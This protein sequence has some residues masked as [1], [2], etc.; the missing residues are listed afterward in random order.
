MEALASSKGAG[1]LGGV[2]GA[3]KASTT[4]GLSRSMNGGTTSVRKSANSIAR[5]RGALG[6]SATDGS[7]STAR[8]GGGRS[9]AAAG[10]GFVSV[11]SASAGRSRWP[12]ERNQEQEHERHE[13]EVFP[14]ERPL[15]ARESWERRQEEEEEGA[16][17]RFH[18]GVSEGGE[19]SAARGVWRQ[20]GGQRIRKNASSTPVNVNG[21]ADHDGAHQYEGDP[22]RQPRHAHR[23]AGEEGLDDGGQDARW[24][25]EA[26]AEGGRRLDSQNPG[27]PS[28]GG[29]P[30]RA[31]HGGAAAGR[32]PNG[33]SGR[34]A[35]SRVHDGADQPL[36]DGFRRTHG[37][38][39]ERN[40]PRF[41]GDGSGRDRG[42]DEQQPGRQRELHYGAAAPAFSHG[43]GVEIRGRQDG[44]A[45]ARDD[46]SFYRD[47]NGSD[48]NP[49]PLDSS[50]GVRRSSASSP[51]GV[52]YDP[53]RYEKA[54][55]SQGAAGAGAGAAEGG[56]HG[57]WAGAH[58]D[59]PRGERAGGGGRGEGMR[60]IN[61]DGRQSMRASASA[62]VAT[63]DRTS[64]LR[65][66]DAA[67]MGGG[68]WAHPRF[69]QA[70]QEGPAAADD[71]ER[72]QATAGDSG[73]D[74]VGARPQD[75]ER[76]N[77][78]REEGRKVGHPAFTGGR[79][80]HER[81]HQQVAM[82]MTQSVDGADEDVSRSAERDRA[83][84]VGGAG[85]PDTATTADGLNASAGAGRGLPAGGGASGSGSGSGG[86][87]EHVLRD[88][89]RV[90]LFANG[91]QKVGGARMK[92]RVCTLGCVGGSLP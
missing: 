84:V 36:S 60:S 61:S 12:V 11:E 81:A 16:N 53:M 40:E 22:G 58:P 26:G 82:A 31:E 1:V 24:E 17:M 64:P 35:S 23:W 86:K 41:G 88:G 32:D 62:A 67:G 69:R 37:V 6:V 29:L 80:R 27:R 76:L 90:I 9:T 68:R 74:G 66:S 25:E 91:T 10:V 4:P 57:A 18:H 49:Q 63:L 79:S 48:G 3:S 54:V 50:W 59:P 28:D 43:A 46:A 45:L 21:S 89:R 44:E 34:S 7:S 33:S 14:E 75:W 56:E 78:T 42:R 51:D 92:R 85:K 2:G 15:A 47:S 87:V 8:V 39:G 13:Q 55:V 77:G 38:D 52:K 72:R 83:H 73:G 5:A 20:G 71:A 19:A 70:L 30:W 65:H